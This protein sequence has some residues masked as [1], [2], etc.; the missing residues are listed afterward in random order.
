MKFIFRSGDIIKI[1]GKTSFEDL[2]LK[3]VGLMIDADSSLSPDGNEFFSSSALDEF[4]HNSILERSDL[5]AIREK[6]L[7]NI[8]LDIEGSKRKK[9]NIKYLRWL[10]RELKT[11]HRV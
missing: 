10:A 5:K 7:N 4:L 3:E 9:I 11:H 1:P 8:Y 6:I 2:S